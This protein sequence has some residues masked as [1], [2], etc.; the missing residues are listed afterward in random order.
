MALTRDGK[1]LYA[2]DQ[3]GFRMLVIDMA[4]KKILHNIP[5]G[6]YPFGITLSPDEQVA[7]VA[8]VGVF[9]YKPFTDLDRKDLKKTAHE[10]PSSKYG[11]KE[12]KEGVPD[13]GIP[14]LGDPNAP[15][16]FSVWSIRLGS[17]PTV[18]AKIKTGFLVGQLVEDFPAVGGSSPNSVVATDQY[19]F[20]EQRQQRLRIGHRRED[21]QGGKKILACRLIRAWVTCAASSRSD[22]HS[23]PAATADRANACMSPKRVSTPLP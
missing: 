1:T 9:A 22:W 14:A 21:Q 20:R 4:S 15:E 6:R 5:T 8:N 7:Y 12:M 11:S 3:I 13:K 17:Q 16:A 2:L 18:T 10:Y 23:R 19:V